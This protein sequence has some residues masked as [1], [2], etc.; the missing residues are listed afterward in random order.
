M[1][2]KYYVVS[3]EEN[4]TKYI[5]IENIYSNIEYIFCLVKTIK[6]STIKYVLVV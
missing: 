4:Q 2:Y 5:L 1:T 6:T 3:S